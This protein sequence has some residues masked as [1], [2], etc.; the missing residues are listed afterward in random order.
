MSTN[1]SKNGKK[2][3][4]YS[5]STA[6]EA[7]ISQKRNWYQNEEK[8]YFFDLEEQNTINTSFKNL[9]FEEKKLMTPQN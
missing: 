9:M 1:V 7:K 2:L 6:E 8:I 4:L 3:Q 5:N